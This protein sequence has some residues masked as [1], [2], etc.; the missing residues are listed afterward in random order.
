[1]AK[2][3]RKATK[4]GQTTMAATPS[5]QPADDPEEDRIPFDLSDEHPGAQEPV[6]ASDDDMGGNDDGEI[7]SEDDET[8]ME[9]VAISEI[10]KHTIV[11]ARNDVLAIEKK[12]TDVA[13]FDKDACESPLPF[14]ES[15]SV[16][17]Q[18][19]HPL[20]SKLALDD[21]ER[22]KRF[23]EIT[24]AAVHTGLDTLR[25]QRVKFRR[26]SDFFAE[27]TKTDEHMGKV[28][29]QILF[30][31]ERIE[32]AEKRKNNRDIKKNKRKVRQE[33]IEKE[34]DKKRKTRE[35]IEAY[36]RLRQQ[37]LRE[38]AEGDE[39]SDDDFPID[40][41]DVEQLDEENRFQRQKDIASGKKKA[42]R[43]DNSISA[44]QNRRQ[45]KG[46]Q[47]GRSE[48]T[49]KRNNLVGAG[50]RKGGIQ[51]KGTKKRLGKS[52]RVA[53]KSKQ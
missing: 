27:M 29:S 19:K 44:T 28:K 9:T 2:P 30:N 13:I 18:L 35:E 26:P 31:K 50:A 7:D 42:W 34:Q 47:S 4:T 22:E 21:L 10:P 14:S 8:T 40:M 32:A 1:M 20:S 16:K 39:P 37:R 52:R 41:L 43:Q 6:Q 3:K 12:L 38:R 36:S 15:L 48:K 51:K 53:G 24:A 23:A 5:P 33:Q 11:Q 45:S 46:K 17:I 25:Q 49:G